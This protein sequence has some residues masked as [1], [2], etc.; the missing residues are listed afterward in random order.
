[1]QSANGV[2]V[3]VHAALKRTEENTPRPNSMSYFRVSTTAAE[4]L[5][6]AL[7]LMLSREPQF[8]I[9]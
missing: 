8:K 2:L 9:F 5:H 3:P 7:Q 4:V 1:M 6:C